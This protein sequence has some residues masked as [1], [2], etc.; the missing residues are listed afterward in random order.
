MEISGERDVIRECWKDLVECKFGRV[1]RGYM[2]QKMRVGVEV[3]CVEI[4]STQVIMIKK[5]KYGKWLKLIEKW[6]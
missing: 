1:K 5:S 3:R 6:E 2:G 4:D